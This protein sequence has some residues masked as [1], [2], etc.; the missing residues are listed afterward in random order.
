MEYSNRWNLKGSNVRFLPFALETGGRMHP[1]A[2]A[3]LKDC[4]RKYVSANKREEWTAE[5]RRLY[6]SKLSDLLM[7]VGV[8]VA[9][10]RAVSLLYMARRANALLAGHAA[11]APPAAGAMGSE[12]DSEDEGS[13]GYTGGVDE[14]T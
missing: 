14:L 4:V 5:E 9:R 10:G 12:A 1:D 7:S 8:S 2:L 6:A 3:F 11:P 13:D